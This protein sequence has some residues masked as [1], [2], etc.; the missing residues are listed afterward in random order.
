MNDAILYILKQIYLKIPKE[1]LIEAFQP[2][3]ESLDFIIKR[4]IIVD[5][6]L[7]SCNL[8]AGKIT[9]IKLNDKYSID[10]RSDDY[11]F[12]LHDGRYSVYKIPPEVRS[13]RDIIAVLDITYPLG[14]FSEYG[15]SPDIGSNTIK[16]LTNEVMT[17]NTNSPQYLTPTPILL[18]DNMIRLEP[19]QAFHVDWIISCMLKYDEN[20]NNVYPNVFKPLAELGVNACKMYIYNK[21]Y[22]RINQGYL[23]GGRQ[24]E[25]IKDIISDYRDSEEKF[26]EALKKFRGAATFDKDNL[27][28]MIS[29]M[30]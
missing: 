2:Q 24:L 16:T 27:I 7:R 20:F 11:P 4:D 3:M 5:I 6:V 17:S 18:N 30:V 25:A 8:F 15:Y 1:I 19:P 9:K 13:N 21:L 26:N 22:I 14:Q 12:P 28:D 29:L 10:M 23:S